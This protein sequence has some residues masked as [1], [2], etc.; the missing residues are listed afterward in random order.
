MQER[1]GKPESMP[2]RGMMPGR[3]PG[4]PGSPIGFGKPKNF[5]QTAS[6]LFS[7][8]KDSKL[9][10][11]V[12]T[13]SLIVSTAAMLAGSYALKPL[14]N[15]YI[16]PGDFKGL[17]AALV[18]L[19]LILLTGVVASYLQSRLTVKIAQRTVNI[20]RRDLFNRMQEL[21]I[22]YFDRHTH[23]ELMSRYTNDIENVQM[24]LEQGLT[25]MISSV[26]SF[27]GSII[28]MITL[29]PLL[30]LITAAV[31]T[32]MVILSIRIGGK[33]RYYFMNQQK[34]L[35][36][37]NGQIEESIGGLREIKVFNHEE[38][39]KKTFYDL[40]EQFR[41]SASKANFLTGII[42][43]L[44]MNLN[45]ISYAA[46]AVAGGILTLNGMFDIGSLAAFL[47]IRGR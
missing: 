25:Q 16:I 35:G 4:G 30:F 19:G 10:I 31:M 28:I 47:S 17:L 38:E 29:S 9:L 37:L 40:N 22:N 5:R 23:G 1:R 33:S 2:Q 42:M 20:L 11:V 21:E 15:D 36:R 8:L 12:V 39:T 32:V 7:Y 26:L 24:M 43:P 34:L 3:G 46:V 45:N 44:T 13:I 6:R 18:V 41:V 27:G 14:I